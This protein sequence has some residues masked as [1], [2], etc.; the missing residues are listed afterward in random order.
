MEYGAGKRAVVIGAGIGGLASAQAVS[1]HFEQVVILERDALPVEWG[2]RKG[3]PQDNHPHVLLSGGLQA[4][5]TLVPGIGENLVQAGAARVR[6]SLDAKFEPPGL[7]PLP[8]R[9][10]GSAVVTMSRPLIEGVLRRRIAQSS[11]I[12]IRDKC[13]VT[14]IQPSARDT[15]GG[16]VSF[17]PADGQPEELT[18]DLIVDASARGVLTLEALRAT[19]TPLPDETVIEVDL[20]YNT[21]MIN[22]A[23]TV[24]RD[25]T[26]CL[27]LCDPSKSSRWGS[28]IPIEA[29]RHMA[30]TAD[31]N[32]GGRL[33]SD[34]W[35]VFLDHV[36]G[37]RTPTI[38]DAIRDAKPVGGV[39]HFGFPANIWRH[40]E[41]LAIMPRGIIPMGDAFCRFNPIYGQGMT[42]AIQQAVLLHN[43][44][45]SAQRSEDPI[46]D[47]QKKFFAEVS[48]LVQAAWIQSAV[49]DFNFP[50]TNG[51]PPADFEKMRSY[52]AA[53][54]RAAAKD[55]VVHRLLVE[56][57]GLLR[58][59]DVL[60]SPEIVKRVQ[61]KSDTIAVSRS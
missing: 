43:C 58:L 50:G 19:G 28:L 47:A 55:E 26:L 61:G 36:Q 51:T 3:T 17:E 56:V 2:S 22:A 49:A 23:D 20:V 60:N 29:G 1:R 14:T 52:N 9:D 6:S 12:L 10:L 53:L 15:A 37:L 35:G 16:G 39:R 8:R 54:F 34:E 11:N 31:W 25:W 33:H 38:Y 32:G 5:E 44:L 46:G 40:F 24:P 13:R 41:T 57:M 21:V 27:T 7:D 48:P 59:P 4:L 45:S 42:V 30:I 18:A